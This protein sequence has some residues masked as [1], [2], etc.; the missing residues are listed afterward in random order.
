MA[1]FPLENLEDLMLLSSMNPR[2]IR[3]RCGLPHP[4]SKFAA[5]GAVKDGPYADT[6]LKFVH[7]LTLGEPDSAMRR[8]AEWFLFESETTFFRLCLNAGINAK[9]LRSH[10]LCKQLGVEDVYFDGGASGVA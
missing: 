6:I 7:Y 1:Q 4:L 8:E 2:D 5:N 9:K 3:Q 10:L